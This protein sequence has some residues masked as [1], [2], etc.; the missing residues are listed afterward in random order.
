MSETAK[1][2]PIAEEQRVYAKIL[3]I[4]MYLGLLLLLVTF[5]V[6]ALGIMEPA[7]PVED[8]PKYWRMSAHDYLEAINHEYLHREHPITGWAWVTALGKSDYLNYVG[9]VTLSGVTIA[10]FLGIIPVLLRKRDVTYAVM[11][12]LEALILALAASGVL[13]SGGH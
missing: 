13:R 5:A 1:A 7:V 8:L 4:G 12:F 6:Y 9:I 2:I 3:E 11:S 10:C